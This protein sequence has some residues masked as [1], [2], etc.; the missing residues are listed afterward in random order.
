MTALVGL[1]ALIPAWTDADP[2][3]DDVLQKGFKDAQ[4]S[5]VVVQAD[6]RELAKIN[7]DFGASYRFKTSEATIKEPFKLRLSGKVDDTEILFI[8]N[9]TTQWIRVPRANISQKRTCP[10]TRQTSNDDGLR[11]SYAV[12]VRRTVFR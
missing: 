11:R 8:V 6:Q 2:T 5:I 10:V 9:G 12:S 4:F 3:L 1:L 7:K